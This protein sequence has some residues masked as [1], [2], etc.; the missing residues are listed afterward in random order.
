[1]RSREAASIAAS[2]RWSLTAALAR[3][4]SRGMHRRTDFK[5]SNDALTR[6]II[7]TGVDS[8]RVSGETEARK[9]LAS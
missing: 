9:D 2:G 6:T 7:L 4:E 8:I 5:A 1:V 3:Q